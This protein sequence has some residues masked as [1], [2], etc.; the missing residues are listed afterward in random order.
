MIY[1]NNN[2]SKRRGECYYLEEYNLEIDIPESWQKTTDTQF[3]LQFTNGNTYVS[4]FVYFKNQ[5]AEYQIPLD[6]SEQ[7]IEELFSKRQN[8]VKLSEENKEDYEDKVVYS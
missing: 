2:K 8:V 6:V 5:L 1:S 7:H 4:L 3:D